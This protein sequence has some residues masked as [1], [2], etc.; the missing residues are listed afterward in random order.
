MNLK[1]TLPQNEVGTK[2]VLLSFEFSYEN[3]SENFPN[4]GGPLKCFV[5]PPQN[6]AKLWPNLPESPARRLEVFIDELSQ[7]VQGQLD[8]SIAQYPNCRTE[9]VVKGVGM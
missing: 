3:S 9:A 5:P 4:F 7:G 8:V 6:P 2:N 1:A